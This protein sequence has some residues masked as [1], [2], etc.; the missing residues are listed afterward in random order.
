MNQLE[1]CKLFCIKKS[2]LQIECL[3]VA[4]KQE[5]HRQENSLVFY[6]L[7]HGG[8]HNQ[9]VTSDGKKVG[10]EELINLVDVPSLAGKP[11]IFVIQVIK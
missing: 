2:R 6:I 11:K 4:E 8:K 7:T 5:D 3:T 9:L 10:L 1:C